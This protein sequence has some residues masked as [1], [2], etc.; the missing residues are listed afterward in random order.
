MK[1]SGPS[2]LVE[3]FG[4]QDKSESPADAIIREAQWPAASR[5]FRVCPFAFGMNDLTLPRTPGS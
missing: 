3:Q 2:D 4:E 5:S 1:R